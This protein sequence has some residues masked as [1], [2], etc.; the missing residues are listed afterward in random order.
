MTKVK[1]R[2]HLDHHKVGA[3]DFEVECSRTV[4]SIK[5]PHGLS[6]LTWSHH[7]HLKICPLILAWLKDLQSF[8]Y[9][10]SSHQA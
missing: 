1:G 6:L 2:F 7:E 10:T 8:R 9:G 4:K 3:G 5:L